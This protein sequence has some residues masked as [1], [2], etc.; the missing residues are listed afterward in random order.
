MGRLEIV[1]YLNFLMR[2]R[3]FALKKTPKEK[4]VL[5]PTG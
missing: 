1:V 2:K 5:L 3:G 4:L